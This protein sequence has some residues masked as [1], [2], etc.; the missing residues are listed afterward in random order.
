MTAPFVNFISCVAMLDSVQSTM[1][2][3]GIQRRGGSSEDAD[4]LGNPAIS[5]AQK[6]RMI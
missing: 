1:Q 4:F 5:E 6:G 3:H 2:L